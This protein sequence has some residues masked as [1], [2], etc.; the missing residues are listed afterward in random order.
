M[1]VGRGVTERII[2]SLPSG[3]GKRR[4]FR[5]DKGKVSL[6]FRAKGQR[7]ENTCTQTFHQVEKCRKKG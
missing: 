6:S 1:G 5:G 3:R 4:N 7:G 2:P